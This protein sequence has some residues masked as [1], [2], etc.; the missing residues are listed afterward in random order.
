M[1][2][3]KEVRVSVFAMK[4][5]PG[6]TTADPFATL[7]RPL[8]LPQPPAREAGGEVWTGRKPDGEPPSIV[9]FR[10]MTAEEH[11]E[12]AKTLAAPGNARQEGEPPRPLAALKKIR[13][14]HHEAARMM[15]SGLSDVEISRALDCSIGTL[16]TLRRSPAFHELLHAY[17]A[18]PDRLAMEANARLKSTALLALERVEEVLSSPGP[19]GVPLG[20]LRDVVFPLL[21]RAGFAPV[22]KSVSLS[23][24]VGGISQ[25]M[26]RAIKEELRGNTIIIDN[27]VPAAPAPRTGGQILPAE[28]DV[29]HAPEGGGAGAGGAGQGGG[30][31]TGPAPAGERQ[32]A[33]SAVS[34]SGGEV[35]GTAPAAPAA[36]RTLDPFQ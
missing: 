16:S 19:D 4:S 9:G 23:A 30:Q 15:A 27:A 10:E 24:N 18:G 26:L 21:D 20:W 2:G 29:A 14:W 8:G 13:A 28:V 36:L 31:A 33:G 3:G 34:A 1:G 17:T 25:E 35:A 5:V 32:S 22:A 7:K 11:A 12:A 6:G